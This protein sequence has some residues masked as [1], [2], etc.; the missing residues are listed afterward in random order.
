[1]RQAETM[2]ISAAD[3]PPHGASCDT[4]D[5]PTARMDANGVLL[6]K[7]VRHAEH[8]CREVR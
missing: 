8:L 2:A 6:G 3:A 7:L 5:G 4:D 1:M